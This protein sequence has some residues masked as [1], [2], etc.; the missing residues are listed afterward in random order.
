MAEVTLEDGIEFL[1]AVRQDPKFALRDQ[2]EQEEFA[3]I[4]PSRRSD[5]H[6][7]VPT[8]R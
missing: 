6:K 5:A 7:F 4:L 2:A 1:A 3:A 8:E